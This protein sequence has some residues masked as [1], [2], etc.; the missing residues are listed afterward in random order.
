MGEILSIESYFP[1]YVSAIQEIRAACQS[2]GITS[3]YELVDSVKTRLTPQ[4]IQYMDIHLPGWQC[5]ARYAD[6]QTWFHIA[7]VMVALYDLPEY[8]TASNEAQRVQEWA[9]LLHDIAK[10]ARK[11]KRDSAHGF[12][13]AAWA[14]R[15]LPQVGFSITNAY[16]VSFADWFEMVIHA[17][18]DRGA[19]RVQDNR[20]LPEIVAGIDN[21][22]GKD[23]PGGWILK[24]ILF[25]V[26]LNQV[27]AWPSPAPLNDHEIRTYFNLR[28]IPYLKVITLVDS[29]SWSLFDPD[30]KAAYRLETLEYFENIER[31][32]VH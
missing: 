26:S 5:M 3:W 1:E 21:M 23:T 32:L 11:E 30:I 4:Y 18:Q 7:C 22:F 20:R 16:A 29:D 19:D 13:S 28:M 10:Q 31:L 14:A 2:G 27:K 6:G 9:V 8:Q 25:H 15:V 17:Y 12:R 24:G